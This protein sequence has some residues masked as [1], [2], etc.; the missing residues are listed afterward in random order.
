MPKMQI[1]TLDNVGRKFHKFTNLD[2]LGGKCLH[3]GD[4]PLN[5]AFWALRNIYMKVEEGEIV[6]II[7]RNGSGKTTLLNIISGTLPVSE[8]EITIKGKTSALLTLGAGFQE[9]FTGRENIYLGGSLLGMRREEIDRRFSEILEFSE[10]GDFINAPMGSY[11]SGMKLRL[12]FSVAVHNDFDILLTDEILG[13]GD[14]YFQKKCLERMMDFKRQGKSLLIATQDMSMIERFCDR[15][16]MLEDGKIFFSGK[17]DEAIEQYQKL[18]N[19]KKILSETRRSDMVTETKRWAT[20]MQEWGKREGTREVTLDGLKILDWWGR[21]VNEI[22]P[23]EKITARVDF[24]AHEELDGF[25]FGVAVFREDGVYCYG[26][27]TQLDGLATGRMNKGKGYF[28]LKYDSFLLEPG[29]YYLSAAVWDKKETM[30][31][32]YH[33]CKYRLEVVGDCA[34]G[35][36]LCLPAGWE[37]EYLNR[38]PAKPPLDYLTDKWAS[39]LNTETA[40][41]TDIKCLNNY[42]SEEETFITGRDLKIRAGF[43]VNRT[44][45]P[46]SGSL[47]L[48]L[49][50]YRSDNIYCH[51]ISKMIVADAQGQETLAYPKLKLLPGGYR[52]SAGIFDQRENKFIAYSHGIKAFNMISEKR[53]HG[54]VYLDHRWNWRLPKGGKG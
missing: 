26:P 53:D 14:I 27:N 13:V 33:K 21:N 7:G 31:H 1:I 3:P 51:G 43:M 37:G 5:G 22:R 15:V 6:G 9:E 54:T 42:G 47:I 16:F 41:I 36:L 45:L 29:I 52:V 48:W 11:S 39:E 20:D 19:K 17:S 50:I 12:G 24:T 40:R 44:A 34:C 46:L 30:A 35:Q 10:L 4:A 32:D 49:G 38:S 8:G 18:L 2:D 25:H 23:G 28:E